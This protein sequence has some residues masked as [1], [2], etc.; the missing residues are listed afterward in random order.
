MN[1]EERGILFDERTLAEVRE[2]F[3]RIDTDGEG[4]RRL[5]DQHGKAGGLDYRADEGAGHQYAEQSDR[6]LPLSAD[7]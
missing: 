1:G 5:P 4:K 6:K 3:R 7:A 2:R